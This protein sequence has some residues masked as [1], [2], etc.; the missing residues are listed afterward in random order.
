MSFDVDVTRK[1]GG[2]RISLRFTAPHGITALVGPSGIGKTSVLNMIAGLLRP[3]HGHVEVGGA[4]LFDSDRR[5]DLS[6]AERRAG[7]VFQDRRLFPH[8]RVR[9]N[10]R[11]GRHG[12]S[13]M[14]FDMMVDMLGIAAL[15]DRW[16]ATL[17]GGEAQRVAIGRALLSS[18]RFLLLDEPLASLDEARRAQI[19]AIIRR[20][21]EE[22]ALP[23]LLVSHDSSDVDQL[24][25]TVVRMDASAA[26]PG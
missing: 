24:A 26:E 10:L 22:L 25:D 1:L 23:I 8:M 13:P 21:G 3:D 15:L 17:S 16:P 2:K 20:V 12:R 11:Y 18:P 5:I 6:V 19:R 7:Y 4:V 14:N 9:A